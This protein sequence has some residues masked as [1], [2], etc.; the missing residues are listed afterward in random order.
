MRELPG[1]GFRRAGVMKP[2][3]AADLLPVSRNIDVVS[4]VQGKL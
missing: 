2:L 4:R 3:G 1:S